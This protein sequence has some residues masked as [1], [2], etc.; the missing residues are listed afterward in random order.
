MWG[1]E[2]GK[3]SKR[4]FHPHPVSPKKEK[5]EIGFFLI[6]NINRT[7]GQKKGSLGH[8]QEKERTVLP[9]SGIDKN[10]FFFGLLIPRFFVLSG[11]V[12][13]EKGGE[14]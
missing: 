1:R 8:G 12:S 6:S 10:S 2:G 13:N 4:A 11:S 14:A 7:S 5:E 3:D 9:I